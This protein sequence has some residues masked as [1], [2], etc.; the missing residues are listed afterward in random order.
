MRFMRQWPPQLLLTHPDHERERQIMTMF[1]AAQV[2]SP[3]G[4]LALVDRSQA[5]PGPGTVRVAVEACGICHSDS[6]F[7]DDQWP[8]VRFPVTPVM[9]SPGISTRSATVW[10]VGVRVKGS[11]RAPPAHNVGLLELVAP[12]PLSPIIKY[13]VKLKRDYCIRCRIESSRCRS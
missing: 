9:R 2:T 7:V 5:D 11:R 3:R 10:R 4:Q 13:Y 8:S 1:R 6:L 12:Q